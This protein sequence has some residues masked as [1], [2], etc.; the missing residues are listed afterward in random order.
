MDLIMND[1]SIT[2]QFESL[3]EFLDSIYTN[4]LPMLNGIYSQDNNLYKTYNAYDLKIFDD[5]TINTLIQNS[6]YNAYSEVS[7]LKIMLCSLLEEP[8]WEDDPCT[9]YDSDYE[10]KYMGKFTGKEPNCFSEALERK[11]NLISFEHNEF[12]DFKID[13]L[14]NI[15]NFYINNAFNKESLGEILFRNK[16]I[17][18]SEYLMSKKH[19]I[20]IIFSN[21]RSVYFA[22]EPYTSGQIDYND[23]ISIKKDFDKSLEYIAQGNLTSRFSDSI[24][25]KGY[26][27]YEFRC[28]LANSREFRI[29]YCIHKRKY[30]YFNSVIKKT[31]TINK[32]IKDKSVELIK[33][34]IDR[35]DN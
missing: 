32:A 7:S 1:F 16:E 20:D 5:V 4:T 12:K 23:V 31:Q 8:Y 22:D 33:E 15:E 19:Q 3:D 17:G 26:T 25:H 29:Y 24:N 21:R 2:G 6:K 11:A 34:Y 27:Y 10:C 13:I 18:F 14:K 35:N 9:D 28:S 30:V